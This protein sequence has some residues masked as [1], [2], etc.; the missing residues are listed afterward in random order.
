MSSLAFLYE[1]RDQFI[2]YNL[3]RSYLGLAKRDLKLYKKK[4][5]SYKLFH[6]V[7]GIEVAD[8][9]LNQRHYSN[10]LNEFSF[11][12]LLLAIK[13]EQI[14]N[15]NI[16]GIL[17]EYEQK[18][19]HLRS[20]LNEHFEKGL[21]SKTLSPTNLMLLDQEVRAWNKTN[22]VPGKFIDDQ[23]YHCL[24]GDIAYDE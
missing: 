16:S 19:N 17:K 5:E 6:F 2:T 13:N 21:I 9:L 23:Q 1:K 18:M 11:K 14:S 3:I 10:N 4:K 15:A 20:D 7:R 22:V 8:L 12:D 24:L